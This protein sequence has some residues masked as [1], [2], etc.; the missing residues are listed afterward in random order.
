MRPVMYSINLQETQGRAQKN[1]EKV[2]PSTIITTKNSEDTFSIKISQLFTLIKTL[3]SIKE[4]N[5]FLFQF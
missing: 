5:D 2:R 4:G 1:A 3:K